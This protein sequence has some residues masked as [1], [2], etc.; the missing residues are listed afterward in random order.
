VIV[1]CRIHDVSMGVVEP[2]PVGGSLSL[3]S[4]T[5]GCVPITWAAARIEGHDNALYNLAE[6]SRPTIVV[7]GCQLC[8]PR[9]VPV[10][11][12][13]AAFAAGLPKIRV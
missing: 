1:Y 13:L 8:G 5:L 11:Q 3:G 10:K 2:N 6:W 12:L 9:E 4:V 7:E